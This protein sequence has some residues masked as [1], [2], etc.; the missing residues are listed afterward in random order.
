M[1]RPPFHQWYRSGES[2]GIRRFPSASMY[3]LGDWSG[4]PGTL[5]TGKSV[6]PYIDGAYVMLFFLLYP[7]VFKQGVPGVPSVPTGGKLIPDFISGTGSSGSGSG[8]VSGTGN[9]MGV[10]STLI[11]CLTVLGAGLTVITGMVF[12]LPTKA[13]IRFRCCLSPGWRQHPKRPSGYTTRCSALVSPPPSAQAGQRA[14]I[15]PPPVVRAF[16]RRSNWRA[17]SAPCEPD[18]SPPPTG[19]AALAP[20][21]VRFGH[22]PKLQHQVGSLPLSDRGW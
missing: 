12:F 19:P 1:D 6:P 13:K 9:F 4:T 21:A 10:I 14:W 2:K 20:E 22:L 8:F 16:S 3:G 11:D 15:R 17:I 18:I 7:R 5:G